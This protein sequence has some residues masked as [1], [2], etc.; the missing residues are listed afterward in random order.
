MS[1][2]SVFSHNDWKVSYLKALHEADHRHLPA[3]ISA[4]RHEIEIRARELF[5]APGDNIEE[6][7]TLRD[8][9]YALQALQSCLDFQ[10]N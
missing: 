1:A 4:A 8:A 6:V 10:T 3:R 9:L 7:Q 2:T 5:H